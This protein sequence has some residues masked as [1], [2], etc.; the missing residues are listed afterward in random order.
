MATPRDSAAVRKS[1]S[2]VNK[3]LGRCGLPFLLAFAVV[4]VAGSKT[5]GTLSQP[6]GSVFAV[7]LHSNSHGAGEWALRNS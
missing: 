4:D 6:N 2:K 1:S 5:Y 7:T 3:R